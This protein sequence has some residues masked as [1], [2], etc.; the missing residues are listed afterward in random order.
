MAE[1]Y[2]K[3]SSGKA[4]V[5][6]QAA[7]LALAIYLGDTRFESFIGKVRT[8][9]M[10]G[11]KLPHRVVLAGR[12]DLRLHFIFSAALK[13][14]S[15]HNSSIAIGEFKELLDSDYTGSGFSFVDLA[16][17]RAGVRFA[18]M[19]TDSRGNAWRFQRVMKD[20]R[21]KDFFPDIANLIEGLNEHE[22]RTRYGDVNSREYQK[23]VA[24]IDRRLD[25]LPL[26]RKRK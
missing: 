5:E 24:E 17:D 11:N 14:I 23:I 16:A 25:L 4:E 7:I 18:T 21:E 19:A 3:S 9:D 2:Q 1:A 13:I 26:Y 15:D 20:A 12:T 22:F 10:K 8:S 6:N